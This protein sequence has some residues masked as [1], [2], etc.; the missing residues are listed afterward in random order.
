MIQHP[1]IQRLSITSTQRYSD[2]AIQRYSDLGRS[3]DHR[4]RFLTRIIH[5]DS[6]ATSQMPMDSGAER[7][8]RSLS[9]DDSLHRLLRRHP[10]SMR[11]CCV[12]SRTSVES[13]VGASWFRSKFVFSVSHPFVCECH[14]ISTLPSFPTA[15]RQTGRVDF[16]L[17]AFG[18]CSQVRYQTRFNWRFLNRVTP[19]CPNI[20]PSVQRRLRL[21]VVLW[22]LAKN[23]AVAS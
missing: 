1:A 4:W 10:L 8:L 20:F 23:F 15:S 2:I 18:P 14:S 3:L 6:T 16:L 22:R 9:V 5:D 19:S 21:L 12:S 11:P 13:T 7:F 17:P